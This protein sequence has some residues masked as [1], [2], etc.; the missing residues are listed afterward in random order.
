MGNR[1]IMVFG[2]AIAL[3]IP[4]ALLAQATG[5]TWMKLSDDA[6]VGYTLG[7]MDAT[8]LY[9]AGIKPAETFDSLAES[10]ADCWI[11]RKITYPVLEAVI[12]SYV[13]THSSERS[14]ELRMLTSYAILDLCR[15]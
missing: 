10:I 13:K 15:P 3:V 9:S 7:F 1:F 6:K 12:T 11:K 5:E 4:S 14:Q 8:A 2:I